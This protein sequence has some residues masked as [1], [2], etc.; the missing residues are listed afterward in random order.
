MLRRVPHDN[1]DVYFLFHHFS[2]AIIGR[3]DYFSPAT[4]SSSTSNPGI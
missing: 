2:G 4:T 1:A 3:G